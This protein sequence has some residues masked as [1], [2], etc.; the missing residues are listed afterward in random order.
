M[1]QLLQAHA[2]LAFQRGGLQQLGLGD[3]D[4]VDEHEAVLVTCVGGDDLQVGVGDGAHATALHLLE[5][6]PGPDHSHEHDH[7]DRLHVGAGGDHV[8]GDGDARVVARAEQL[9]QSIRL[10]CRRRPCR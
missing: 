4:G 5:E 10:C 9:D 7:L 1:E 2:S 3:A 8:D 6:V